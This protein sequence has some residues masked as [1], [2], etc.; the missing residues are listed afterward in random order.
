MI[1]I[2][3]CVKKN[4]VINPQKAIGYCCR[5][6]WRDE[7]GTLHCGCKNFRLATRSVKNAHN[8]RMAKPAGQNNHHK[9]NHH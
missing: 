8:E 5:Q 1:L 3:I 7:Q 9:R 4:C 2:A 6:T